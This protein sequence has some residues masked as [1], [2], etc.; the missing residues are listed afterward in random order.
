MA[1]AGEGLCCAVVYTAV[2]LGSSKVSAVG[3]SRGLIDF[4][5]GQD[6]LQPR[7]CLFR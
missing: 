4:G 1:M 2:L 3:L 7:R 5:P 6:G